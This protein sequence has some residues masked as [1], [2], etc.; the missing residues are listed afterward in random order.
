MV[1]KHKA[2]ISGWTKGQ[3]KVV[4]TMIEQHH[5]ETHFQQ[6]SL[7]IYDVQTHLLKEM[8]HKAKGTF[9]VANSVARRR[10]SY[11]PT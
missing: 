9:K 5:L 4:T 7:I 2:H 3:N 6:N 10:R 1:E 8:V 11:R